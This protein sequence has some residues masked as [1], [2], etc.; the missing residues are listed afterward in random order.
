MTG[1]FDTHA[2]YADSAFD[3]DREQVLAELPEK[4]VKLVMLAASGLDDS[5]EN[6]LL[7]Q[8]YGYV[9]AAAGVH[10]ESVDETTD[11][12][13]DSLRE[14]IAA[15]NKI[16]AVGEIGL[17]YHYDGYDRDLQIRFFREQLAFANELD[18]P[19]IV[20]SRDAVEDTV[21][22]LSEYRPKGVVHCFSGS[23]ETAKEILK[24]G[25]Y[26]GFTGVLTF[27]NAKKALKALAEVPMDKLL[28]ETDCPY[29]APEPFRGRRCDSSMIAYTAAKAAEIKGVSVQELID[30]TCKN[31]MTMYGIN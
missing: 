2:H 31:G 26:I 1:I 12:Y 10:P 22:I 28:M 6:S 24:L 4:G 13:L 15:N 3:E 8:K 17:D 20:H 27:K 23:A 19:V 9:Y 11:G 16:K 21:D 30:I 5:A 7:S 25:M 14:M 18:M 29:M